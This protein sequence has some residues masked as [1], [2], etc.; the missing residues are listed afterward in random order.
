MKK[1][2]LILIISLFSSLLYANELKDLYFNNNGAFWEKWHKEIE[3]FESCKSNVFLKNTFAM[4]GNSEVSE[5]IYEAI[6]KTIIKSPSC[7]LNSINR[8]SEKEQKHILNIFVSRP[9]Y[10]NI[11]EIEKSLKTVWYKKEYKNLKTEFLR[12]KKEIWGK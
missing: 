8:L 9:L 3:K 5:T 10:H 4:S 2:T 12:L 7:V 11:N 1:L 6:E